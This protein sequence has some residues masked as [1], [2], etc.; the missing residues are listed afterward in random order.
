M[1]LGTALIIGV[2]LIVV[3]L[4]VLKRKKPDEFKALADQAYADAQKAEQ[5][6]K[7]KL[8]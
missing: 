2:I 3:G 1:S 8:K 7:D 4:I 5:A 6:I